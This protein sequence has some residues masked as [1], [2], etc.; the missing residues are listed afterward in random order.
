MSSPRY[1]PVPN[2]LNQTS[3]YRDP[4]RVFIVW[5][6]GLTVRLLQTL[7]IETNL[8]HIMQRTHMVSAQD[9]SPGHNMGLRVSWQC[10]YCGIIAWIPVDSIINH[11]SFVISHAST[12]SG[13]LNNNEYNI[14][15]QH[16]QPLKMLLKHMSLPRDV[17]LSSTNHG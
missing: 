16:H 11:S 10:C 13:P 1:I 4:H 17:Q 2:C 8:A 15:W 7:V 3:S 5:H 9:L 12:V 14:L 6:L